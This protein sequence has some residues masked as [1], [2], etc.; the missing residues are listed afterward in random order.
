[1]WMRNGAMGVV[2]LATTLLSACE[3]C[4]PAPDPIGGAIC[5]SGA[6][7]G[8]DYL[9]EDSELVIVVK[10]K[11]AFGCGALHSHVVQATQATFAYALDGAAAGEVD[12]VVPAIGLDPDDPE[13][14]LK[15]LP[16]GENQ[17]LSDGDRQSIKGSV[18]EEVLASEHPALRFTLKNLSAID[19]DGTGTLVAD[20]AGATSEV[21]LGYTA[22]K[23]GDTVK[24]V[25]RA[26]LDGAP[27]GMPRNALGFCVEPLMDI[28]FELTLAP[29]TARCDDEVD[30]VPPF[31]ETFFPDEDCGEVGYTVVYNEVVGPRCLGC[32]GGTLPGNPALLRGGATEPLVRW[33]D[34]RVDSPRNIG[35]PMYLKAHDYVGLDPFNPEELAMPPSALGEATPLQD[36]AAPVTIAGTTYTSEKDLF[37]AWVEQGL[38]RRAQCADDVEVKTFGLN[39]GQAVQPGACGDGALRYNAPQAEHDDFSAA[40]F[41]VGCTSCHSTGSPGQAPAAAPIATHVDDADVIDFA[42]GDLPV[43]H[44]FYVD[45]DGDPLSFW[46]ASIHRTE[47]G[48]M[49]PG[50]TIGVFNDDPAFL[51][52]KAWV[53]A[54][55]CAPE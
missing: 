2:M 35:R 10:K 49:F 17:A 39:N 25:G 27:H 44:P 48:S 20:I 47:D 26:V 22:M 15:Y 13:L 21:V 42:A 52:F 38:G 4:G 8:T 3:G 50:A 28:A 46:E 33:E 24:L 31:E 34:W 41:F 1:M 55:A 7:A 5:G 6:I 12:I 37:D 9:V 29:G 18:N 45:S 40:D 11:D 32:H 53:A 14:R 30:V 23:D 36:L 43:T 16:D 54:G 19:G 51:A